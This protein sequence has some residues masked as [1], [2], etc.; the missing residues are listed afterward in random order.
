MKKPI[1][2]K[3]KIIK[4]PILKKSFVNLNL[5]PE[6][7]GDELFIGNS[8]ERAFKNMLWKTKRKGK[9]PYSI[10]TN[11]PLLESKLFPV[12][13]KKQ[14]RHDYIEGKFN[15]SDNLPNKDRVKLKL[16][17]GHYKIGKDIDIFID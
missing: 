7:G 1:I 14:E 3:K 12:F 4:K 17:R 16:K 11:E 5:H 10:I 6:Q 8:N 13:I 9:V 2:E 15:L